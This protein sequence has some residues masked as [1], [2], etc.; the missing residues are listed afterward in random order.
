M[1]FEAIR[2]TKL[3]NSFTA[4][5]LTSHWSSEASPVMINGFG[6]PTQP[7]VLVMMFGQRS[8]KLQERLGGGRLGPDGVF[9]L[10]QCDALSMHSGHAKLGLPCQSA[11]TR[12]FLFLSTVA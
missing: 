4:L 9:C 11:F 10:D 7:E 3:L 5:I 8:G 12:E 2:E 1:R 6:I